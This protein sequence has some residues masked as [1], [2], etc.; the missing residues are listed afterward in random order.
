MQTG[1]PAP[2]TTLVA[3]WHEVRNG[4]IVRA[5]SA[6]DGR[7]FA[8][9]F[10]QPQDTAADEQAIRDLKQKFGEALLSGDAKSRA[11]L[12]VDDGTVVPPQGGFYRGREA[13][14]THFATEAAS[15][16]STS[17]ISFANY[18]FRFITS[19]VAFVDADIVLNDV[20]G[21]DGNIVPKVPIA[22]TFTALR[23]DGA[24]L[25]QD[26]RAHFNMPIAA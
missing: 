5:R 23:K 26:E 18:R 13:M 3:E 1:Q 19:D 22:V 20:R 24:W 15:I 12:W 9:M 16:T 7:P 4:K 8:A 6:F 17:R 14:A 25:I 11:S 2:A 21:P 10:E